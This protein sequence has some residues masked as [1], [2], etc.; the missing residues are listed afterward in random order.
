[1]ADRLR[2]LWTV[3]SRA[4]ASREEPPDIGALAGHGIF[5]FSSGEQSLNL[6]YDHAACSHPVAQADHAFGLGAMLAGEKFAFLF[7]PVTDDMNTAISASRSERMDRALKTVIGQLKPGLPRSGRSDRP[8]YSFPIARTVMQRLRLSDRS[9]LIR[10]GF[11]TCSAT[12]R[13]SSRTAMSSISE[14]CRRMVA[15]EKEN[16]FDHTIRGGNFWFDTRQ[17]RAA[18]RT[19]IDQTTRM[20]NIGFRL[21]RT[22]TP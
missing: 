7:E 11:T 18:Y 1:M 3:A 19:S 2:N 20:R 12:S 13:N 22:I 5:S 15:M 21:V 4:H 14:S 6:S 9:S 10:L 16:C 17:V 8:R